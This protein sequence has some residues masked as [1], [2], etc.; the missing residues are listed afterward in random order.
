MILF[1]IILLIADLFL[2][3]VLVR[4][5]RERNRMLKFTVLAVKAALTVALIYLFVALTLR[6]SMP[7]GPADAYRQ[8][9]MGSMA[10]LLLVTSALSVLT[11]LI[12]GVASL[13]MKRK[14]K[15]RGPVLISVFLLMTLLVADAHFRQRLNIKTVRTNI[16][17]PGLDPALEGLKIALVSDLH[18]SSWHGNYGRLEKAMLSVTAEEPD[19]LMNTGDFITYS[20]QEFGEC[21]TILRKARALYGAFAVEGNHDDGTYYPDYDQD[22]GAASSEMLMKKIEASGYTLLRDTA[23]IINHNGTSVAIAGVVTQGH[24]LDINYGDF[25]KALGTIPDSLFTILLLHDP[26]GWLLTSVTGRMPDLTVSGHTH[27]LQIGL[28]VGGWSPAAE[29][30]EHWKGVYRLR[31]SFLYVT[32]GLGSMG[33]SARF[34]MPPEIVYLTLSSYGTN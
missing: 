32:T 7:Y 15:W 31:D 21:D 30:H 24:R 1:Y 11:L 25:K 13:V 18:L 3:I 12:A 23:V 22:Y 17:I 14:I 9:V 5:L 16:P 34:F 4:E 6:G 33:M 8:I 2:W 10:L 20:W 19:L 28:P 26:E 29:F 27:G